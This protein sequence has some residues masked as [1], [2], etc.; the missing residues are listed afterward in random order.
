MCVAKEKSR[1]C[2]FSVVF[3]L[4]LYMRY[5][6]LN[7][8]QH[9]PKQDTEPL[10]SEAS[11][12]RS[13]SMN[14]LESLSFCTYSTG[15]TMV[16]EVL[17]DWFRFLGGKP[18][19]VVFAVSFDN[20]MPRIYSQL[21]ERGMIDELIEVG[22]HG[23]PVQEVDPEGIFQS[24]RNADREWVCLA[25][26]DT[27]PYRVGNDTWLEDAIRAIEVGGYFGLGG[28]YRAHEIVPAQDGYFKTQKYSNN[29]CLTPKKNWLGAIIAEIGTDFNQPMG[30][31]AR[32]TGVKKRFMLEEAITNYLKRTNKYLLFQSET[33]DWTIFHVNVWGDELRR[34]REAYLRR[35]KI[36]SYLNIADP[37]EK[38]AYMYPSWQRYYGSR[39][40][41]LLKQVRTRIGKFRREV[42]RARDTSD[43]HAH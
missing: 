11:A 4:R 42:F 14:M 12:D 43:H 25:K 26:L 23:R 31:Y 38:P 34:V 41:S 28:S 33:P 20:Q 22:A 5:L 8:R 7:Q 27:L 17:T 35:K 37:L 39:R 13:G 9:K 15:S 40:P 29:C 36:G 30:E 24:I 19:Q 10:E 18:G 2:E 21:Q 32:F 1:H 6:G 16:E 3:Y